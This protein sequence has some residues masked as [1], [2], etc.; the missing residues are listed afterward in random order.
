M[1]ILI[2][3]PKLTRKSH[4]WHFFFFQNHGEK[5]KKKKKKALCT[6]GPR[7][8]LEKT[9]TVRS[10]GV[11]HVPGRSEGRCGSPGLWPWMRVFV[12]LKGS[13]AGAIGVFCCSLTLWR[14]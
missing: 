9:V 4:H 7:N 2:L 14:G 8:A 10:L 6:G 1:E 5:R 11:G 3:Y 12:V 13:G